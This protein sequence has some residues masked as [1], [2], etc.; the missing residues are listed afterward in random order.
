MCVAEVEQCARMVDGQVD[1][2]ALSKLV[3]V[4]VAAVRAERT[5]SKRLLVPG[6]DTDASQHRLQCDS[7]ILQ[8]IRWLGKARDARIRVDLPVAFKVEVELRSPH[9]TGIERRERDGAEADR[10]VT[11]QVQA[12][13]L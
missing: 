10:A 11:V 8:P 3:V 12:D 1:R 4:H 7:E 6:R 2:D 13:Q 9:I 5:S